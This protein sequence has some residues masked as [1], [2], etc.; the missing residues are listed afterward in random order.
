MF[1]KK[2]TYFSSLWLL[3][4]ISACAHPASLKKE[5]Y[6]EP[7]KHDSINTQATLTPAS[8]ANEPAV[9]L[10]GVRDDDLASA[11]A[12]AKKHILPHWQ[13]IMQRSTRVR[14]RL[15]LTLQDLHAPTDLQIIPIV[16][17]GYQ[18]YALSRTG[19]MG[20]WQL[21]P[22]TARGL[23]I[24]K[25]KY[26]DGRRHIE[27]STR[28]AVKYLQTQ[29]KRF[30]NWPL[31][32]AAYNMG[33]NG[34][35]RRLKKHT[36]KLSDGLNNMPAPAET[37]TYVRHII[38]I[39]ALLKMH[40]LTFPQATTT[41][42]I[43]LQAPI[44][45]KQLALAANLDEK[46]L[47]EFNP[48]LHYSQY[49]HRGILLHTPEDISTQLQQLSHAQQPKLL[50]ITIQAGD[51]LWKI[52]HRSHCTVKQLQKLNPKLKNTLKIGSTLTVPGNALARAS[53][54]LN[55][56]L[57][58]G[59][60]IHYK[61]RRGDSLWSI[62][63]RFGTTTRSIARANQLSRHALIRPGDTLWILAHIRPS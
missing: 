44:D 41:K 9:F 43:A 15:I 25:D 40:T 30:G 1:S 59:R 39:A 22:R 3:L 8:I 20:L 26:I 36:W 11:Q 2:N 16:E 27:R 38:G 31:A 54:T 4:L 52:A 19:A 61:V 60:R 7:S 62:S 53:A 17:S 58:H 12:S 6:I 42:A 47:F 34:L 5:A 28:A 21:M 23:G 14:H 45:L 55:P 10:K 32:F 48:G 63:R 13:N 56:L 50:Q 29:Y 57:S 35:A 51:S 18:P 24:K 33:P 49:L 37:R 46:I